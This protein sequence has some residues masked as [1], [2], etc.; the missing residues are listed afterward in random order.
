LLETVLNS[1][2][3]FGIFGILFSEIT[4]TPLLIRKGETKFALYGLSSVKDE[5]LYRL[6]R[7]GRVHML[8]PEEDTEEWFNLLTLH[9]VLKILSQYINLCTDYFIKRLM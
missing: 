6:F 5:R 4:V 1:T 9:Q 2:G 3:L 8:R 7:E